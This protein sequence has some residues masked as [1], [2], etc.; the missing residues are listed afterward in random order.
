M[1]QQL[2]GSQALRV[3]AP[4]T[5]ITIL[6]FR[7]FDTRNGTTYFVLQVAGRNAGSIIPVIQGSWDGG[8]DWFTLHD[9]FTISTNRFYTLAVRGPMPPRLRLVM[10]PL[11]GFDG[12]F[13][14]ALRSA[15]LVD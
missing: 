4:V 3:R 5:A 11:G 7:P 15:G 9:L 13:G 8:D 10:T 2:S 1:F 12:T 14:V 6:T